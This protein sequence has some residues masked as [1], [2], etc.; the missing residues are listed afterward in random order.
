M[1][2]HMAEEEPEVDTTGEEAASSEESKRESE[3]DTTVESDESLEDSA[4]KDEDFYKAELERLEKRNKQAE[5][6][7]QNLKKEKGEKGIPVEELSLMENR[8]RTNLEQKYEVE[9]IENSASRYSESETEKEV[10]KRYFKAL[11]PELGSIDE[12]MKMASAIAN[13]SKNESRI[14]ELQTTA[15]SKT[16]RLVGGSGAGSPITKEKSPKITEEDIIGARFAGVTPEEFVRGKN[17]INWHE[18]T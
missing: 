10:L 7:I 6:T 3:E 12:R 2:K 14:R 5:Y 18:A 4:A 9:T 8:I 16:N 11:A 1:K 15:K 17:K 13:R